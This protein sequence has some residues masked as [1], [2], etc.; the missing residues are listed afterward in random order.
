[1]RRSIGLL[2][3]MGL[4]SGAMAK[5]AKV[6]T[7]SLTLTA[8]S[9]HC[10]LDPAQ[11]VDAAMMRVTE[12]ALAGQNKL[13]ATFANCKHLTDWRAG[14]RPMLDDFA[15][16]QTLL[17]MMD[18]P[19]APPEALK[20]LCRNLR[21]EGEK[22]VVGLAPDIKT[23]IEQVLKDVK[24]NQT[25]FLGV[26]AEEPEAC[27]AVLVQRM[28]SA[29][30]K[31]VTQVSLFATMF[32]KGKIVYYYLFAP[33]QNNFTVT[34]LLARHKANVAALLAANKS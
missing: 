15:Q 25:R 1:V 32:L 21:E 26:V 11:P 12:A 20:E 28:K 7:T 8:P 19:P 4:A 18:A 6:G 13:L 33:Y 9:G 29:T 3:V 17:S 22:M 34:S 16:Y 27:Y 2:L 31:D 23:R 24:V 5:D 30:G 10:E 14:K